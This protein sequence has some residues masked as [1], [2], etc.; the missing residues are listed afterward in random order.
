MTE[1]SVALVLV[2]TNHR[3]APIGVREELLRGWLGERLVDRCVQVNSHLSMSQVQQIVDCLLPDVPLE[4][5]GTP[6][7][8]AV[9]I[10]A[11]AT[12]GGP[13]KGKPP[14][15]T[16]SPPPHEAAPDPS[17]ASERGGVQIRVIDRDAF[18]LQLAREW[19]RTGLPR[20]PA[21]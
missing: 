17:G 4:I 18:A 16:G 10:G 6:G 9:P 2:G 15:A 7:M 1:R 19:V 21:L 14:E 5:A 8:P 20:N 13:G 12:L 3:H 11:A